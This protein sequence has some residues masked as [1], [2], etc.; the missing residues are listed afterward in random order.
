MQGRQEMEDRRPVPADRP[1]GPV[2]APVP[3][4]RRLHPSRQVPIPDR[5]AEGARL[6]V[7]A[8]RLA[9]AN[10]PRQALIDR[11]A[12]GGDGIT[13]PTG[14]GRR[15]DRVSE[16][17]RKLTVP[18]EGRSGLGRGLLAAVAPLAG[19]RR[20]SPPPRRRR[21]PPTRLRRPRL[22]PPTGVR[23]T[24]RRRQGPGPRPARLPAA[25]ARRQRR[26]GSGPPI[27]PSTEPSRE[28]IAAQRHPDRI[29]RPRSGRRERPSGSTKGRSA[30]STTR[31]PRLARSGSSRCSSHRQAVAGGGRSRDRS[32][33]PCRP[34][35]SRRIPSAG[36]SSRRS[37]RSSLRR[38]PRP[39]SGIGTQAVGAPAWWSAGFTGGTGPSDTVAADTAI[40]SEA[41]DPTH[42]AF[43]GVTVDNDPEAAVTDHGTHTGGII[44]SGDTTY[45]GVAYGR[46]SADRERRNEAYALG[47]AVGPNAGSRRIR[48]RVINLSFGSTA[49]SDDEDDGDDVLTSVFGVGQAQ[50]AGNDNIDGSPDRQQT[51]GA[52]CSASG[53]S[54]MS[55]RSPPS[56]DV[57]LGVSS[58]GPTPGGRKKP[59][60]TAP[61]GAVIAPS[62]LGTRRPP[63]PISPGRPGRRSRRPT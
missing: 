12:M 36:R 9:D 29:S 42:P 16:H 62:A 52:T 3:V 44:A 41:A 50:G 53:P 28:H 40:Q 1:K 58:R 33:L 8:V 7:P 15:R 20:V 25:P 23:G 2:Q 47:F 45:R 4:R 13:L 21:A 39:L 24:S 55:A 57:V 18:R 60:L 56:D 49:A 22:G 37:R 32:R 14:R 46:R 34:D 19:R 61:G 6:A 31:R 11:G 10:G 27:R 54:T 43:A 63:I 17:R 30:A 26:I 51:S 38:D 48:Q 35:R 59:D 5:G